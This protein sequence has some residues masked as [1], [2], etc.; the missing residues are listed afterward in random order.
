[1]TLLGEPRTRDLAEASHE[2]A[3]GLLGR[4][5]GDATE[6]AEL[7]ELIGRRRS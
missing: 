7:T 4:I 3:V 1:V 5:D 6:L 2:R